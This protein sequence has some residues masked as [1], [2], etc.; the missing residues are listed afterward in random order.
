MEVDTK[1]KWGERN[2]GRR[3]GEEKERRKGKRKEGERKKERASG[4]EKERGEK[5]NKKEEIQ[6][7]PGNIWYSDGTR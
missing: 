7:V 2:M 1:K 4:S 6:G 3:K 5:G